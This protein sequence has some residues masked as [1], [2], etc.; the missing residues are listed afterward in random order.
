MTTNTIL[1]QAEQRVTDLKTQA[2]TT[3]KDIVAGMYEEIGRQHYAQAQVELP[4]L[5]QSIAKN[6]RPFLD[7]LVRISQQAKT[8]L[9]PFVLAWVRELQE[10]CV[11]GAQWTREGID[12]WNRLAPPFVAGTQQLDPARRTREVD[13]LRKKLTNWNGRRHRLYELKVWIEQYIQESGWPAAQP[14]S[15]TIAP[16][17]PSEASEMKGGTGV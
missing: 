5:E 12:E 16:A 7:Q 9:P 4:K 6:S 11:T 8:P 17:P 14:G 1:D 2:H 15:T 10:F 3:A 13:S